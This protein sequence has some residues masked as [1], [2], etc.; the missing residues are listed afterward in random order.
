M[1]VNDQFTPEHRMKVDPF[2]WLHVCIGTNTFSG[3]TR[4]T[5]ND[6]IFK[7]ED[8]NVEFNRS[9]SRLPKDWTGKLLIGKGFFFGNW[10]Q[11]L[12][13]LT[14]INIFKRFLPESEMLAITNGQNCTAKGD[15]LSWEEMDWEFN[16]KVDKLSTN[17]E[18][19]CGNNHRS[20]KFILNGFQTWFDCRDNC[21]KYKGSKMASYPDADTNDF[22]TNWIIKRMFEKKIGENNAVTMS[23]FPGGCH[24]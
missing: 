18:E 7:H 9:T 16:G 14:N 22:N 1:N 10:I 15:F 11:S 2:G 5:L 4:I 20:F 13:A 6:Q 23:S 8:I 19:L 24:R 12:G 17:T 21:R 3:E